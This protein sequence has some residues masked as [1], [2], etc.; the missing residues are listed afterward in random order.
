[1]LTNEKAAL[2]VARQI[3]KDLKKKKKDRFID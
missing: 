3:Y 1:M 2:N